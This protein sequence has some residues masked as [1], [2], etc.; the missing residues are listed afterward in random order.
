MNMLEYYRSKPEDFSIKKHPSENLYIVKYKHVGLDWSQPYALDARGIVLDGNSKVVSRPYKK[1]FN[2]GELRHRE[3]LSEDIKSLSEWDEGVNYVGFEKLDG[4]LAVVSQ[5]KGKMLYSSTG[6]LVGEFPDK[7]K[8]WFKKNL[9]KEQKKELKSITRN[10][11]LLFEYVSPN[12]RIV[13]RY[14]KEEM[15]LHG[16]I[17]TKTGNE[18]INPMVVKALANSIGT[19]VAGIFQ[20]PLDRFLSLKS[21]DLEDNMFEGFVV[22]FDS[23]KRVKIKMDDYVE[24]HSKHTLA[25]GN[26][27]TKKKVQ[28]YIEAVKDGTIDDLLAL[29]EER[30]EKEVVEV[31]N[32]VIKYDKSFDKLLN[33]SY[34]ICNH[35]NFNKKSTLLSTERQNS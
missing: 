6:N 10:Y 33:K 26:P 19:D 13:V 23:G 4:S 22:R 21:Q 3:D 24:A 20:L 32:N 31:I 9:S 27:N 5:Y 2:Y 1:F 17:E 30:G 29:F 16:V 35:P 12:N 34:D 11:T 14:E 15:V 7:F 8:K 28:L 18:I 25:F